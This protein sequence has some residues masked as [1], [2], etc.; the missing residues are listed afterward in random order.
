MRVIEHLVLVL[1]QLAGNLEHLL[2]RLAGRR[3][4]PPEIPSARP[5]RVHLRKA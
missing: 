2:R 3:K 1:E 5:M 4:S